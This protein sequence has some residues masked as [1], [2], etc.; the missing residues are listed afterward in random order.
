VSDILPFGRDP[1]DA[2]M[3]ESTVLH[4]A[5]SLRTD[6]ASYRSQLLYERAH[7]DRQREAETRRQANQERRADRFIANAGVVDDDDSMFD[8]ATRQRLRE[9]RRVDPIAWAVAFG[10]ARAAAAEKAQQ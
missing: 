4:L 3:T 2:E 9:L 6:P 5:R 10:L 8:D 7:I 1:R